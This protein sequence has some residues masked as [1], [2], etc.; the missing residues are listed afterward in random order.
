MGVP[1]V[2]IESKI[3]KFKVPFKTEVPCLDVNRNMEM[4][5]GLNGRIHID[6]VNPRIYEVGIGEKFDYSDELFQEVMKLSEK[7][8]KDDSKLKSSERVS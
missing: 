3:L 1:E 2:P 7:E 5:C 8:Q 6:F 4:L